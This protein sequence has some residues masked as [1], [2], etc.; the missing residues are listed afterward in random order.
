MIVSKQ[1]HAISAQFQPLSESKFMTEDLGL[2]LLNKTVTVSCT[3]FSFCPRLPTKHASPEV[4]TV[5]SKDQDL[6]RP[7][8]PE[9]RA[10]VSLAKDEMDKTKT[11]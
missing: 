4:F 6:P 3:V 8:N 7:E 5:I 10:C 1:E 9:R 2:R 11:R